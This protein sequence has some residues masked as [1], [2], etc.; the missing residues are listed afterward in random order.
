LNNAIVNE[1]HDRNVNIDLNDKTHYINEDSYQSTNNETEII[2]IEKESV[3]GIENLAQDIQNYNTSGTGKI[4][5]FE[6][7]EAPV[8]NLKRNKIINSNNNSTLQMLNIIKENTALREMKHEE[9][10]IR[11]KVPTIFENMDETDIFFLSMSKMTKLLPKEEQANIKLLLSNCVLQAEVRNTSI[12]A[13]SQPIT[14]PIPS[15]VA[16]SSHYL[17]I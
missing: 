1:K 3:D 12:Q 16:T 2:L 6:I 11:P 13:V 5:H 8:N 10:I 14:S 4:K 7:A 15:E 17:T 9:K